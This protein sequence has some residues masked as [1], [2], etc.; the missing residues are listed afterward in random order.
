ML[1]LPSRSECRGFEFCANCSLP[2]FQHK[3]GE[4][5]CVQAMTAAL[6]SVMQQDSDIVCQRRQQRCNVSFVSLMPV[7]LSALLRYPR[8]LHFLCSV[9]LCS[10]V[11]FMSFIRSWPLSLF[12]SCSLAHVFPLLVY[13]PLLSVLVLASCRLKLYHCLV[14]VL[15]VECG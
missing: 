4:L 7:F 2:W 11:E 10:P 14:L 9:S 5:T 1:S 3:G 15:T 6:P 12:L 8:C 13:R